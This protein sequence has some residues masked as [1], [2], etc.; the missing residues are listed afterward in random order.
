MAELKVTQFSLLYCILYFEG[1][2]KRI[3]KYKLPASGMQ[4]TNQMTVFYIIIF[5]IIFGLTD[6]LPC[7]NQMATLDIQ[8]N[9][10][11]MYLNNPVYVHH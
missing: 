5:K 4:V 6:L 8:A 3:H 2:L 10:R 1:S 9:T 7:N 11:Y